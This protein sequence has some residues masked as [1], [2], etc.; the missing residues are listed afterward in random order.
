MDP[1]IIFPGVQSDGRTPT[2]IALPWILAIPS[3]A[4]CSRCTPERANAH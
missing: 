4:Q 2:H 1:Q 3:P